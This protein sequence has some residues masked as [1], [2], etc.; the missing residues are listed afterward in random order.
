VGIGIYL[1]EEAKGSKVDGIGEEESGNTE[2]VGG[3]SGTADRNPAQDKKLTPGEIK[4]LKKAGYD[5]EELKDFNA[6]RDLFKDSKGNICV[7][8]KNGKGPG[9]FL[10]ININDL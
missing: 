8:P 5:P 1:N 4:K 2:S 7:K 10:G 6:G 9:D 3:K